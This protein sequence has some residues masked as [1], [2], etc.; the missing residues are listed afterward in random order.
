M[1]KKNILISAIFVLIAIIFTELVKIVD[2][3]SIG[4]N[5]SVVGFATI[6]KSISDFIGVNMLWYDITYYLGIIALGMC[7]CYAFI[8]FIQLVKRKSLLKIDKEIM[9]LA[10]FYVLVAIVYVFFEK[11]IINYRPVL[12]DGVLEAS[13]PSS[14]T[15]MTICI[16]GSSILINRR[17]F[18][19]NI[20]KVLNILILLIMAFTVVGRFISGVHWFTDIVGGIL[21]ATAMLVLFDSLL[22]SL[23]E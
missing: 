11:V 8:G 14:H 7:A 22:K 1:K 20:T 9:M 23:K 13:Y 6:N 3:K 21:I 17:L 16:C 15:L 18:N 2:V 4:P 12:M 5:G 10:A 19:N